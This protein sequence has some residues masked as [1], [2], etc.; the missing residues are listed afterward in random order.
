MVAC[1]QGEEKEE[2]EEGI[3][4]LTNALLE[5]KVGILLLINPVFVKEPFWGCEKLVPGLI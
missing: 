3:S 2:E 1:P 4:S 5:A